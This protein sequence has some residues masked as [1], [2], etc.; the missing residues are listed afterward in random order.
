MYCLR[1]TVETYLGR[2]YLPGQE[3]PDPRLFILN[4]WGWDWGSSPRAFLSVG[5]WGGLIEESHIAP[6][7]KLLQLCRGY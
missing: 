7:L 2:S 4:A 6:R 1:L 3:Y 5:L